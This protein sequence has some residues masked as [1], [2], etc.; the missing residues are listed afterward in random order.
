MKDKKTKCE[1]TVSINQQETQL[2]R[3]KHQRPSFQGNTQTKSGSKSRNNEK[4]AHNYSTTRRTVGI[5]FRAPHTQ[6]EEVNAKFSNATQNYSTNTGEQSNAPAAT[7]NTNNMQ[8]RTKI[9]R[10]HKQ[11]SRST[12]GV[13][14]LTSHNAQHK[15]SN[16][17]TNCTTNTEYQQQMTQRATR[18]HNYSARPTT[19]WIDDQHK[20]YTS[21]TAT[22][23]PRQEVNKKISNATQNYRTN[24]QKKP[25]KSR[26][27][28]RP[29]RL[30]T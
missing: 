27:Y 19:N 16:R 1:T 12:Q 17:C 18:A 8:Q 22:H 5:L 2:R 30:V 20:A 24:Q 21:A 6:S 14:I 13:D 15:A 7:Q 28:V 10:Q 29:W 25:N 9:Y 3:A 4:S 11:T 26:T 23:A